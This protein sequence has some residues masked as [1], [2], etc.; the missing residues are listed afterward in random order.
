ML[1]FPFQTK[2][3]QWYRV[4]NAEGKRGIFFRQAEHLHTLAEMM[5]I[6]VGQ[7]AVYRSN[8]CGLQLSDSGA[9]VEEVIPRGT[10]VVIRSITT[11]SRGQK[12][13]YVAM[14]IDKKTLFWLYKKEIM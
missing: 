9:I 2:N 12:W 13:Y 3:S 11:D 10:S 4:E 1:L 5:E 7:F 6:I 8:F 14:Q